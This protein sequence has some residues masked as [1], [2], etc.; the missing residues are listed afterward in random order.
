MGVAVSRARGDGGFEHDGH[1]EMEATLTSVHPYLRYAVG[2]Q[3][4]VWGILGLGRGGDDAGP[5]S[6]R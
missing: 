4:S 2:E 5:A 6:D 1:S 3:F